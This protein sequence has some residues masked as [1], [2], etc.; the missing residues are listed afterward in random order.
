MS[1][2]RPVTPVLRLLTLKG[3]K[4]REQLM[5]ALGSLE[6]PALEECAVAVTDS[7]GS[8][9]IVVAVQRSLPVLLDNRWEVQT[10]QSAE[11]AQVFVYRR[12]FEKESE[13]EIAKA[14]QDIFDLPGLAQSS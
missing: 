14:V 1:D 4:M 10:G 8:P 5:I 11:G 6:G 3:V 2:R 7:P 9:G 13:E 12:R